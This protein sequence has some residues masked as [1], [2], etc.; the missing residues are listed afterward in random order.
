MSQ[1]DWNKEHKNNKSLY[2]AKMAIKIDDI[3]NDI[4]KGYMLDLGI[5]SL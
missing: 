2:K 4:E 1:N 5:G 3:K